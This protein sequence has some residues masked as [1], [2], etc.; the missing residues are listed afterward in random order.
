VEL[1]ELDWNSIGTLKNDIIYL[2]LK[3]IYIYI[4]EGFQEF[5]EIPSQ[6]N[7]KN[8][9]RF[10][11]TGSNRVPKLKEMSLELLELQIY[12]RLKSFIINESFIV[13]GVPKPMELEWWS[14][15]RL[16]NSKSISQVK[17]GHLA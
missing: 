10:F 1:L 16:G 15:K 3:K 6:K 14:S 11:L 17:N 12:T 5:H 4:I 8:Q 2:F 13:N 9:N 7:K